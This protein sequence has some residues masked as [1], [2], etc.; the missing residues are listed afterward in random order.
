[1]KEVKNYNTIK[2]K[3]WKYKIR[4]LDHNVKKDK[5]NESRVETTAGLLYINF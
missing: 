1:M 4:S 3:K 2:H 5:Q